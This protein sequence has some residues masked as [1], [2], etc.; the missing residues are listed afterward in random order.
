MVSLEKYSCLCPNSIGL[1]MF[2][3]QK[4]EHYIKC[5]KSSCG[6]FTTPE[7][8][9]EYLNQI[10]RQLHDDH[11]A[12]HPL[13]HH[14]KPATL[15]LSKSEK[16]PM[17]VYFRCGEK[18]ACKYFQWGDS[19]AT[20]AT[21]TNLTEKNEKLKNTVKVKVE[22]VDKGTM[23]DEALYSAPK[24]AKKRKKTAKPLEEAIESVE[25]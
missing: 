8:L 21:L 11:K 1:E 7:A 3:S 23:T 25:I 6:V 19:P 10:D 15:N 14:G 22:Y 16:N 20:S 12:Q 24:P 5:K 9:Y 17:R 4:G 18:E 2:K 13:C